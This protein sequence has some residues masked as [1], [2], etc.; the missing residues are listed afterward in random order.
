MAEGIPKP[1][2]T[3]GCEAVNVY[4][5]AAGKVNIAYFTPALGLLANYTIP[6]AVYRITV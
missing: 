6:I 2:T 1:G 3:A 5:E 4:A